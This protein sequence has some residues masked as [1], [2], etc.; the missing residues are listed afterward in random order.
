MKRLVCAALA[1]AFFGLAAPSDS[2]AQANVF[3]GGGVT[4]PTA[5]FKDFGDGDGANLGWM[6]TGGV[7]MPVGDAG[8][9]LGVR[10][11]YGTNNHDYEGDKT[12]LYGGTA[13]ATFAFGEAG[14]V[15][16]FIFGEI[17]Y[18]AHSYKSTDFASF[19]DTEW[20]PFIAGGAGLNFPLGGLSG[21]VVVG[22][23]QGLGTEDFGADT[24]KTTY[25]T[26][27]AGVN[28]PVGGGM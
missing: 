16:P 8:L 1:L 27:A 21:F 23:N 20:K 17:G 6:A 7:Q 12:N 15:A 28:I 9:A 22:Y 11:F 5:D 4:S 26:G 13:L 25:I 2:S 10:G 3:I 18:Q 14:A 24:G 19:E